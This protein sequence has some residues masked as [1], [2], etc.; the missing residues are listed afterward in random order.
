M[1]TEDLRLNI[2]AEII[3]YLANAYYHL[4]VDHNDAQDM[5]RKDS[6]EI[7]RII[8]KHIEKNGEI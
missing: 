2:Q 6:Y 7:I 1:L 4:N 5:A 8:K 3:N